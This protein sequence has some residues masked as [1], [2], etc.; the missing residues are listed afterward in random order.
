MLNQK[1]GSAVEA[2]VNGMLDNGVAAT[3]EPGATARRQ[4]L[5][6]LLS[7]GMAG[8]ANIPLPNSITM[9]RL[10]VDAASPAARIVVRVDPC[11]VSSIHFASPLQ[12]AGR[13]TAED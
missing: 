8:G 4:R 9:M 1:H 10:A 3:S 2:A 11:P 7:T 5:L 6:P 13:H 12:A